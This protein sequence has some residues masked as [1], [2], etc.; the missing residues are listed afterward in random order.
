MLQDVS[1]GAGRGPAVE[2]P[3]TYYPPV[4]ARKENAGGEEGERAGSTDA[5]GRGQTLR[6]SVGVGLTQIYCY[7]GKTTFRL[8]DPGGFD[9]AASAPARP[10][11]RPL[12]L[13]PLPF[14]PLPLPLPPPFCGWVVAATPTRV[15][16]ATPGRGG[17]L[18]APGVKMQYLCCALRLGA[19]TAGHV[20]CGTL[21]VASA[22]PE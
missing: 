10:L 1:D 7:L 14:E 16:R 5:P 20:L 19:N 22:G 13:P 18:Q 11:P 12:A 9:D 15:A 21:Y 8:L 17:W 6:R 4:R 2:D 3:C